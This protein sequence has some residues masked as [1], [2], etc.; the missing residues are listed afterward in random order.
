MLREEIGQWFRRLFTGGAT[1]DVE[2]E[3]RAENAYEW[4]KDMRLSSVTGNSGSMEKIGGQEVTI[5]GQDY[6]LHVALPNFYFHL[7]TAYNL[8]RHNGVELGKRDFMGA[9]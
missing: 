6:L 8:L 2:T 1:P 5:S 9:Y 3:L 4:A 7:S